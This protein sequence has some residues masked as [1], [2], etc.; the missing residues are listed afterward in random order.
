M[1]LVALRNIQPDEYWTVSGEQIAR[2][3]KPTT[4]IR[5]LQVFAFGKVMQ[6]GLRSLADNGGRDR[7]AAQNLSR[8][9]E[10]L[11]DAMNPLEQFVYF[12]ILR[13][14]GCDIEAL[15]RGVQGVGS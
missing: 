9:Y 1:S 3:P 12:F 4:G 10:H 11:C 2:C 6:V 14:L 13:L 5:A 15:A 8:R 7:L